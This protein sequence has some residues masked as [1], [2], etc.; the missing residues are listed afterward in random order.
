M[1]RR[2]VAC[3]VIVAAMLL[4]NSA[5]K[6]SPA[7]RV[8][9]GTFEP[10][11]PASVSPA[12]PPTAAPALPSCP[13]LAT[14]LRAVATNDNRLRDWAN[15]GRYREANHTVRGATVVFLGDSITDNWVQPRF[16]QFFP[17]KDYVGRGISGQTTPQML[18]RMRPDV[19]ALKPKAVIILAGVN[20]ISGLATGPMT[21]E[22][23]AATW[24]PW[25]NWPRPTA[26]KSC[27]RASCPRATIISR[28]RTRSRRPRCTRS[29]GYVSSIG[30]SGSTPPITDI[31]TRITIRRWP[32]RRDA[33]SRPQRGRHSP[34]GRRLRDHGA[35]RTGRHRPGPQV[36]T[37]T[38]NRSPGATDRSP[39]GFN[40]R[41]VLWSITS[42]LAGFLFGFD[43]VVISGAEQKIQA[44]WGLSAGVH[45]FAIASALVWHGHRVALRRLAD[46]S[47]RTAP[48]LARDRRAVH[49]VGGRMRL[50]QRC[51]HVHRGPDDRRDR[52]RDLD[53]GGAAVHLGNRAGGVSR[54]TRRH[55]PVQHRVR[56]PDGLRLECDAGRN[57]RERLAVDARRRGAPVSRLHPHVRRH[58]REPALADWAQRRPGGRR[59]R[60]EADRA[61]GDRRPAGSGRGR[62][63]GGLLGARHLRPVLDLAA[64]RPHHAG[65]PDRVLQS[66]LRHQCHPLFRAAD[67]CDD[68]AWRARR[69]AP[70]RRHRHH[71]SRVHVR[72]LVV[73][74]QAR[75][76]HAPVHRLVRL[77]CLA[78]AHGVGLRHPALQHRAGV[79]LCVHRRSRH[80]SGRG[81]LGVHLGDLS[82]SP[83]GGRA[84]VGQ[85]DALGVCGVAD[86]V[87]PGDGVGV[88][89]G[90]RVC[91]SL[92]A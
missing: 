15:L 82:Q 52:H 24:S 3:P 74:R 22:E 83:P 91:L 75:A 79:H 54:A 8:P 44:L 90:L 11:V 39:S 9:S 64:P 29:S 59:Q 85:F 25:R 2:L 5:L 36:S 66:A 70:V 72:G 16:G 78:R 4:Q 47:F 73:D 6:S 21:N 60:A 86:D 49:R 14:A 48:D 40:R 28:I 61:R 84:D 65:I 41:I 26:S 43:T 12:Q 19:L 55:V 45:G 63:C 34:H 71:Q 13:E 92:P 76:T 10:Q 1:S 18:L 88:F 33:S 89:A 31:R 80:R 53:R 32:T 20:D 62:D 7:P 57:R 30:G 23:I 68:R 69:L 35:D 87:L 17:G 38:S 50:C 51:R 67:L 58:S 46:G 56:H 77:H 81:D 27:S 42:A 37:V